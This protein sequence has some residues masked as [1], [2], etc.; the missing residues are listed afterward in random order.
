MKTNNADDGLPIYSKI[1]A[2]GLAGITADL[3]TYPFD[4]VKVW[5]MVRF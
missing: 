2:A 4:T 5:L 3:C 1:A